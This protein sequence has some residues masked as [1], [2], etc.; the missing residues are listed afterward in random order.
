MNSLMTEESNSYSEILPSISGTS[1]SREKV[2]SWLFLSIFFAPLLFFLVILLV[3]KIVSPSLMMDLQRSQSWAF[4]SS[5]KCQFLEV[6]FQNIFE[7]FL[8]PSSS[9][10]S[11][12]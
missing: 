1:G 6:G 11:L 2:L 7:S 5:S 10:S 12:F 9:L 4:S 8:F 3:S